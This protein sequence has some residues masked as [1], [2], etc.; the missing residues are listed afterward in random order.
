M[1][2]R[3]AYTMAEN[4]YIRYTITTEVQSQTAPLFWKSNRSPARHE[5]G[6]PLKLI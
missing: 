2:N 3:V 5:T 1:R 4:A 6:S